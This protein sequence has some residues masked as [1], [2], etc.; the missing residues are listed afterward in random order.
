[1]DG[2]EIVFTECGYEGASMSRIALR[3]SVSK[4]TL[5]NYFTS[6]SELFAAFVEQKTTATLC[7][8]FEPLDSPDDPAT[9][10]HQIGL[11]MVEV[12]L[13]PGSLVLYRIV[14]SEAG[15]FPQLAQIYWES[16]PERAIAHMS[17][18]LARQMQAGRLREADPAFA[19]EQF[20]ALC[21]TRYTMKRRLQ[22][23]LETS[24]EEVEMVV[25]S[26]V[27][28][29]LDSYGHTPSVKP[30]ATLNTRS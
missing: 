14:V 24:A 12:V 20:F 27:R 29:F 9:T 15:E 19:A 4:G 1:M 16:G 2:A 3:A 25:A 23:I 30:L 8:V 26:A 7:Q 17:A 22:L 5:Y 6:K 10:L 21:Q 28:L 13:S 11:R 18:W